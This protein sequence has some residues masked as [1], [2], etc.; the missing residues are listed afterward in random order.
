MLVTPPTSSLKFPRVVSASGRA[1][2]AI[3]LFSTFLHTAGIT[4]D[5]RFCHP[6]SIKRAPSHQTTSR[7]REHETRI[8]IEPQIPYGRLPSNTPHSV[9]HHEL[10]TCAMLAAYETVGNRSVPTWRAGSD[11]RVHLRWRRRRPYIR[12]GYCARALA[13]LTV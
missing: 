13:A 12:G 4:W 10:R 7:P 8:R 1:N 11:S 9:Q 2:C 3:Y 6:P 5:G